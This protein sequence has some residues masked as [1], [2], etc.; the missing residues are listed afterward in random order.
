MSQVKIDYFSDVLCIWAYVAQVRLDELQQQFTDKIQVQ[1]H[2]IT[3]F[4]NTD[5]RIAQGWKDRGGFKGFN[6]HVLNVA[7][8]FPHVPV[9][10]D[11]WLQ[12]PPK[13]S[14]PSHMYLKACQ[15]LVSEEKLAMDEFN[16]LVWQVRCA[17]FQQGLD[18]SQMQVL[19]QLAEQQNIS[20]SLIEEKFNDGSALASLCGDMEMRELH[21]LEGSPT[22]LLNNG[23]Q[24]LYGNVGYR[25]LEA[26]VQE[27]ID[28]P[29]GI[30]SWC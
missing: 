21:K 13:S 11:L 28:R 26:N 9:K 10:Q 3:L 17:F 4:G 24:K 8:Q 15:L 18:V 1:E 12:N 22:Y 19:H 7:E 30:A 27:L 20:R 16:Q 25:V 29:E 23:R 2:F 5:K 14:A 6:Q